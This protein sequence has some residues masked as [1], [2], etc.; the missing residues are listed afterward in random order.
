MRRV[1]KIHVK[2]EADS[3]IK[4]TLNKNYAK[5]KGTK[6]RENYA[7]KQSYYKKMGKNSDDPIS[8]LCRWKNNYL[9]AWSHFKRLAIVHSYNLVSKS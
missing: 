9:K 3:K 6:Y 7:G 5:D 2:V 4:S 1:K 8:N